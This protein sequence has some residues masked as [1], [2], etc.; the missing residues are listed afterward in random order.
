VFEGERPIAKDNDLLGKF[1]LTGISAPAK[2]VPH[3]IEVTF[4]VDPNGILSVSAQDKRT[5]KSEKIVI[6][7]E[8]ERWS[9]EKI[10]KMLREAEEFAEQDRITKERIEARNSLEN[11]IGPTE[12]TAY[13][14]D[15]LGS[16]IDDSD[17]RTIKNSLKQ[18]KEWWV[19]NA[20]TDEETFEGQLK[21]LQSEIYEED[22]HSTGSSDNH[23]D[24]DL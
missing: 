20:S 23:A 6:N 3:Q 19:S 24:D 22:R 14:P 18:V 13:E 8:V 17:K 2:G 5:G 9:S 16:Q 21:E 15:E 4:E 10:D 12:N 11:D 1:D 7:N